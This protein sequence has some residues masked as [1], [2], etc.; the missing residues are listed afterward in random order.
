MEK[1]VASKREELK[2]KDEKL[3]A[4]LDFI[5]QERAERKVQDKLNFDVS[6][7]TSRFKKKIIFQAEVKFDNQ[8]TQLNAAI[9]SAEDY[10]NKFEDV[11]SS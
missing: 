5:Q 3:E 10:T 8:Y 9:A 1:D 11:N 4:F 2:N 6:L 7:R